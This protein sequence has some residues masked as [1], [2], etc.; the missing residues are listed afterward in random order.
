MRRASLLAALL[1]LS[2]CASSRDTPAGVIEL[3]SP[4]PTVSGPL[5]GGGSFGPARY[6]DKVLVVNFFNPFCGPCRQEQGTLERDWRRLH[7]GGVQFLGVHYVGGQ[8]PSSVSAAR[9]YVSRRGVTYPLIED[10]HSDL[11]RSL[12]IQGIPSTVVVDRG[13]LIRFRILGRVRPGELQS[14][15]KRLA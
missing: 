4:A 12:A 14:L 8:W 5:L 13:G 2:A 11:A 7:G 1:V 15:L 9:E 3:S 6:H 10:P